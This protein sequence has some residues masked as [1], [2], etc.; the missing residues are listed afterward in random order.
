MIKPLSRQSLSLSFALCLVFCSA[1]FA[2]AQNEESMP[3]PEEAGQLLNAGKFAEAE[4]AWAAIA[5]ANPQVGPAW[6]NLGFARHM[7]KNYD[8]A[9]EAW[10]KA[11]ELE[12]MQATVHFNIACALA[13][14]GKKDSALD[15]LEKA[16]EA[17]FSS[18]EEIGLLEADA[19][20]ASLRDDPR[21]PGILAKAKG[22]DSSED[23]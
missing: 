12:F 17:G 14:S 22:E 8:G 6:F 15:H 13:L 21:F 19:D 3:T 5:G 2:I 11:G 10:T 4:K 18:D 23:Q 9:V 20:I 1:L 7:Q 16:V